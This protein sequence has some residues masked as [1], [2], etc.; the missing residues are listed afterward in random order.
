M[1]SDNLYR[2]H[3]TRRSKNIMDLDDIKT[4]DDIKDRQDVREIYSEGA[5]EASQLPWEVRST[6]G[7]FLCEAILDKSSAQQKSKFLD[8]ITEELGAHHSEVA[9]EQWSLLA[10]LK[11]RDINGTLRKHTK[12]S[13]YDVV[14]NCVERE[15]ELVEGAMAE[16]E[17]GESSQED[18][19]QFLEDSQQ[20]DSAS[21]YSE[22]SDNSVNDAMEED[23]DPE[24]LTQNQTHSRVP[25]CAREVLEMLSTL[26]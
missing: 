12:S 6:L 3:I 8:E 11:S 22:H 24:F 14:K 1:F 20:K 2:E 18:V 5:V 17:P 9:K 13:M 19:A 10:G 15:R 25:E 7:Q 4:W 26:S 23:I 21:S 16:D